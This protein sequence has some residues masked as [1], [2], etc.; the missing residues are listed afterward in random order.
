VPIKSLATGV[1]AV[2]LVG[3]AA[4]GVT[5]LAPV[6]PTALQVQPVVCGAPLP[7]DSLDPSAAVPTADRLTDILNGLQAQGVSF[8]S[9]ANSVEGGLG[10]LEA[11][12]ADSRFQ[13][14][15]AGGGLSLSF[16]VANISPAGAGAAT[17]DVTA[18]GPK[19]APTTR[20]VRF[21]NQGGW[22]ISRPSAMALIQ[23][24]GVGA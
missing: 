15:V 17:A 22:K 12:I 2:A 24:A 16:N 4:A 20:N 9:K 11:R 18:S 13:Q 10:P 8:T 6:A 3:A 7:L 1:A 21:V 23:E 14:A 19:L 5:S